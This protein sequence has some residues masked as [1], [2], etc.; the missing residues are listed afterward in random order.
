IVAFNS[1]FF[2]RAASKDEN[3]LLLYNMIDQGLIR[4]PVFSFWFNRN[5]NDGDGG[6]VVFG[7]SDPN[8]YEGEH[9]YVPVTQKGYWQ[10]DMGDVLIG[11]Q[12]TGFCSG[13]CAA[14]A[15]SGTS[16]IAGPTVSE[17]L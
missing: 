13:G 8:H 9:T 5:S 14:I 3:V 1:F 10:F 17:R 12:T 7:G 6:E 11:G 2:S 4:D 15:D 16:L